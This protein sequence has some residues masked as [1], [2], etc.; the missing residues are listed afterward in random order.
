MTRSRHRRMFTPRLEALE[1]RALPSVT[2]LGE[3]SEGNASSWRTF[4]A[5]GKATILTNHTSTFVMGKQSLG[6]V[7]SSVA[8]SGFK[9]ASGS[10]AWDLS[11]FKQLEIWTMPL[12]NAGS[13]TG[14]QP[15]V[16]LTTPTGSYRFTPGN[17]GSFQSNQW[18]KH[19]IPLAGNTLWTR[20]VIGSPNLANVTGLEIHQKPQFVGTRVMYD[21]IRFTGSSTGGFATVAS[22]NQP[23]TITAIGSKTVAE[24]SLLQ[25]TV[26][27]KDPEGKT[28]TYFLPSGSPAGATIDATTGKFSWKPDDGPSQSRSVTVGV[29]DNLGATTTA[30]FQVTVQNQAPS[31]KFTY[32]GDLK[33][34]KPITFS[35]SSMWDSSTA[36][37]TAGYKYS[38]DLN[39]DGDFLDA[40][41]A[42]NSTNSSLTAT[43]ATE[44]A[45]TI[46]GRIADKDGGFRDYTASVTVAPANNRPPT[47]DAIPAKTVKEGSTLSFTVVGKD[48]DA[49][50]SV[51]YFLPAGNPSNASIDPLTGVFSWKP[52]DGP[53]MSRSISVGVR[54]TYGLTTTAT[55]QATLSNV[56][57]T[58]RLG[59]TGTPAVGQTLTFSLTGMWDVSLADRN[60]GYKYSFDLNNDGDFTDAGEVASGVSSSIN[61]KPTA[62]GTFTI[63]ARVL[64]KDGGFS[65]YRS[66]VTVASSVNRP[67]TL[68]T[69]SAKSVL[70][71]NLLT[72]NVIGKDLDA[73][74]KLTYFLPTGAPSGAAI[75]PVTGVFTWRPDDG[76]DMSRSITVGVRDSAGASA[77]T[78][79][80]VTVGN[81]SPTAKFI[82]TGTPKVGQT[83]TLS[84]GT[85]SDASLADRNAGFK[86]SFDLNN[87]GDFLDPGE[88]SNST[89]S[90]IAWKPAAQGT[91][92]LRGRIS[93][94]DSGFR[95]YTLAI[96]IASTNG[97][98][99]IADIAPGS[100]SS[101]PSSLLVVGT[102]LYFT[103]TNPNTGD[104]LYKTNGTAAGTVLVKDIMPGVVGSSPSNFAGMNGILYFTAQDPL[105]GLELWRSDGTAAGTY[106]VKDINPGIGSSRPTSLTVVN[107]VLYF[108]AFNPSYGTELW[109]SNGTEAGTGL[110]RDINPGAGSSSP[111]N[112]TPYRGQLAFSAAAP[113]SGIEL[114]ITN[115]TPA[116][117]NLVRDINPGSGNSY[118]SSMVV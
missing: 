71:G 83:L 74:Q 101:N 112:L 9:I 70:E 75:D 82:Y 99:R 10:Q 38:L 31:A 8:D 111:M 89:V 90:S 67:P 54:D 21:G 7:S 79:F 1:A 13:W 19:E 6:F 35:F 97:P 28:V 108:T 40:G 100:G 20:Q 46:R 80:Q 12:V 15:E 33:T 110:V 56:A 30:S 42:L 114:Y 77:T 87:D 24:G 58:A 66:T 104:E 55:F 37:R 113:G 81:Q 18:L 109:M 72:V 57:P 65:D 49:G 116:G 105:K 68:D 48:P 91:F 51:T 39:N 61:W 117:T 16:V 50:Q 115:G 107:G 44:G 5:D 106:M 4:A 60:A 26:V 41:E 102:N 2:P 43:F 76:P 103:A 53:A 118:I 95:D 63:L 85:T 84:L 98:V 69:I 29:R 32:A 92:T 86:Y 27:G 93:D 59:F 34:G 25:F 3:L 64:D 22:T 11:S 94:K 73:G 47:I 36:D 14:P 88:A 23:P 52:D 17:T 62:A 45:K 78:S 96:T